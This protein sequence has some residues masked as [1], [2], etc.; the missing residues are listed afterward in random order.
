LFKR[1]TMIA[2]VLACTVTA[3][4]AGGLDCTFPKSSPL[5]GVHG[6]NIYFRDGTAPAH[7][8]V[9]HIDSEGRLQIRTAEVP[10]SGGVPS[11]FI[12]YVS[13]NGSLG[14]VAVNQVSVM[15]SGAQGRCTGLDA[16]RAKPITPG[17]AP[18]G[19]IDLMRLAGVDCVADGQHTGV[20]R[21]MGNVADMADGSKLRVSVYRQQKNPDI[22][23]FVVADDNGTRG[24]LGLAFWSRGIVM[25]APLGGGA[26]EGFE[27]ADICK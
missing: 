2:G 26:G 4:S 27:D 17:D 24:A 5:E 25:F 14:V 23:M 8:L 19:T 3:A 18:S 15:M 13:T 7:V 9:T 12:G 21:L 22:T 16:E 11:V 6:G 10:T 1:T 20:R